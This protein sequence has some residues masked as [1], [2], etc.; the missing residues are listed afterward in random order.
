MRPEFAADYVVKAGRRRD[1]AQVERDR[2]DAFANVA[3][4]P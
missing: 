2:A 1:V 3:P 4:A